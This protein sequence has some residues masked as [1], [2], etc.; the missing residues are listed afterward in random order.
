MQLVEAARRV[1]QTYNTFITKIEELDLP[2]TIEARPI[3]DVRSIQRTRFF[4]AEAA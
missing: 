3:L 4:S 1:V 2:G